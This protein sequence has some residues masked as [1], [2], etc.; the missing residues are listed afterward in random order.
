MAFG[1]S[2]LKSVTTDVSYKVDLGVVFV[3]G[4]QAL[5]IFL[6]VDAL[7]SYGSNDPA[8]S[9]SFLVSRFYYPGIAAFMVPLLL[10]FETFSSG[11]KSTILQ[12]AGVFTLLWAT[13]NILY[14]FPQFFLADAW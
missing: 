9:W 11:V 3:L 7:G 10:A 14:F 6:I 1:R 8:G 13:S 5:L 12:Y 2:L 4:V